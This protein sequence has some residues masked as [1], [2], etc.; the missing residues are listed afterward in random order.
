MVSSWS[1]QALTLDPSNQVTNL[2][3]MAVL[4]GIPASP[5]LKP[6]SQHFTLVSLGLQEVLWFL[7]GEFQRMFK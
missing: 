7:K 5:V 1:P 3:M 6:P 4:L 2:Q